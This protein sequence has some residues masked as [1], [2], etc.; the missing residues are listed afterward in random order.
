MASGDNES[1]PAIFPGGVEIG[2]PDL[3]VTRPAGTLVNNTGTNPGLYIT[4]GT[5]YTYVGGSASQLW[6]GSPEYASL[7]LTGNPSDGE[8]YTLTVGSSTEVYTFRSSPSATNDVQ[9]G[10]SAADT[11]DSLATKID[12]VQGSVVYAVDYADPL[13]L[14]AISL[15]DSISQTDGTGGDIDIR[16][17]SLW[18][19]RNALPAQVSFFHIR[20]SIQSDHVTD[21]TILVSF[22]AGYTVF[23]RSGLILDGS[24]GKGGDSLTV[25]A[26]DGE[27]QLVFS[28]PPAP[29]AIAVQQGTANQYA[30]SDVLV[31]W[32][33]LRPA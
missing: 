29:P 11:Q 33:Y 10:A 13:M 14:T 21:G 22:P 12:A 9:I 5:D 19:G 16:T 3:T 27:F 23:V 6:P 28:V 32:G 26:F 20:K 30:A 24:G 15:E 1:G 17:A 18:G 8:T 31:L 25:K 4:D 7:V 2:V